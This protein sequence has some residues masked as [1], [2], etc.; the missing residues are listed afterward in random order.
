[1]DATVRPDRDH[2]TDVALAAA[3][4][5]FDVDG[6][7]TRT[8]AR[9]PTYPMQVMLAVFDFPERATEADREHVP[10]LLVDRVAG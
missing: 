2:G 8:C 3:A 10:R 7:A 1:M 4:V 9:P 6:V 5:T